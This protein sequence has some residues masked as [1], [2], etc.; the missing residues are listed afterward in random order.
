ME[1]SRTLQNRFLG[2]SI[3]VPHLVG[4]NQIA[5]SPGYQFGRT[6]P[7]TMT[8]SMIHCETGVKQCGKEAIKTMCLGTLWT[9]RS[10]RS[11]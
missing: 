6:G 3:G 2:L 11:L 7:V 8:T 5:K 9:E 10:E 1:S 4:M